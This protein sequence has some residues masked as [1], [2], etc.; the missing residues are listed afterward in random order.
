MPKVSVIIPN[1]NHAS[2]LKQ[3][4]DSVLNQT[5]QDFEVIILDD[6]SIDNS[7]EIIELY[8]NHSKISHF[9]LNQINSGNTFKQWQKGFD[10]AQGE[11]IWIAE[12]DDWCEPTLLANLIVGFENEECVVS[13]CQ[14]FIINENIIVWKSE[15]NTLGSFI[16][17]NTFIKEYMVFGNTICN[18]SM[19][20]FKRNALKSIS[21]EYQQFS[22]CGDW[23][24]WIELAKQGNIYT[25]GKVLNYFRKHGNDIS[26]KAYSTGLNFSEEIKILYS[27]QKDLLIDEK[28]FLKALKNKYLKFKSVEANFSLEKGL[29]I[30]KKFFNNKKT[31]KYLKS[32]EFLTLK[33]IYGYMKRNL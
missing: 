12:S 2:Y 21:I 20:L 6:C 26:G 30:R 5:Y 15:H 23:L 32:R 4:I 19:A 10:L 22:F 25:T 18:A 8:A 16:N 17:G 31:T 28:E 29:E 24:F 11:L 1:Y 3:R 13:Y 9:V 33:R 7:K 27:L 14:S